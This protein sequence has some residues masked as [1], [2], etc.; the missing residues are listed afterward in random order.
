MTLTL[1]LR[2]AAVFLLAPLSSTASAQAGPA[3]ATPSDGPTERDPAIAAGLSLLG[4]GAGL[5]ALVAAG[6]VEHGEVVGAAGRS[7]ALAWPRPSLAFF[8]PGF[9]RDGPAPDARARAPRPASR[10]NSAGISTLR[11]HALA[12]QGSRIPAS[13]VSPPDRPPARRRRSRPAPARST[14]RP[15]GAWSGSAARP[16]GGGH[17]PC[18]PAPPPCPPGRS[19]RCAESLRPATRR[20][21]PMPGH[22]SRSAGSRPGDRGVPGRRTAAAPSR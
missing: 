13:S 21:R 20:W 15:P 22:S 8:A 16:R 4:A 6:E 19:R 9:D 1:S 10:L 7:V 3:A 5:A 18:H 12:W 17:E 14:N 11:Y 2:L